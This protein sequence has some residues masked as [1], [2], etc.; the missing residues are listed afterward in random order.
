MREGEALGLGVRV[1]SHL[2]R[3]RHRECVKKLDDVLMIKFA[4][5][6]NLALELALHLAFREGRVQGHDL[7]RQRCAMYL[8]GK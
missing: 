7:Y 8:M 6:G 2:A 4:H 3:S 5:Q 1:P